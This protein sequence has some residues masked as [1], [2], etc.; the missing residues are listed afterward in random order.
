MKLKWILII[1][2][3]VSLHLF[4][5]GLL[6]LEAASKEQGKATERKP[7]SIHSVVRNPRGLPPENFRLPIEQ[8]PP[9][10]PYRGKVFWASAC[11][12]R[13]GLLVTPSDGKYY[14]DCV[15]SPTTS[16]NQTSPNNY[17]TV[18]RGIVFLIH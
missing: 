13:S 8:K 12:T 3:T 15:D 4:V 11:E 5:G 14:E 18:S 7:S 1:S 2:V 17:N 9:E 6:N 10:P 16:F